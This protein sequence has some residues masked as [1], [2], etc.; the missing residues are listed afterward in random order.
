MARLNPKALG[1]TPKQ[2]DRE[3]RAV[4]RSAR[5]LSSDHPRLIK[6]HPN[7]WVGVCEGKVCATDKSFDGI[8]KKLKSSGVSPNDAIIRYVDASGR[9]LIL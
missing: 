4:S 7:E 5:V 2:I 6:K 3:L 9:K 8:V 1:A